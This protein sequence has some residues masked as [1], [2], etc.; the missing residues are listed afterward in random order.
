MVVWDGWSWFSLSL[1]GKLKLKGEIGLEENFYRALE[2][3]KTLGQIECMSYWI[4]ESWVV[5]GE[6]T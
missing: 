4:V 2:Y 3:S 1:S 5:K 6:P